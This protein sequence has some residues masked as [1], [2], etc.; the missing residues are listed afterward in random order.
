VQGDT[1]IETGTWAVKAPA[2]DG[3]A[4]TTLSGRALVIWKKGE[5]GIWRMSQDMWVNGP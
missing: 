4:E 3:S 1:M 2:E 5:D